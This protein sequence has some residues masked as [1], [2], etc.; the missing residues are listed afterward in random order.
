MISQLSFWLSRH[1]IGN[2][3]LR[4]GDIAVIAISS[5]LAIFWHFSHPII[6]TWDSHTYFENALGFLG[7]EGRGT[8]YFRLPALP[9]LIL[10]SLAP[11]TGVLWPFVVIQAVMGIII[12][13]LFYRTLAFFSVRLALAA[14]L[15][16]LCSFLPF[17]H[18]KAVMTEHVFLFFITVTLFATARLLFKGGVWSGVL[19]AL[20]LAGMALARA[21]GAYFSILVVP[22][23]FLGARNAR[24]HVLLGLSL[25]VAIVGG[26]IYWQSHLPVRNIW[27]TGMERGGIGLTHTTGKFL[28]YVLYT[29]D[30]RLKKH[31][32][33]FVLPENG[34]NTKKLFETVRNYFEKTPNAFDHNIDKSMFGKYRG[35]V[36]V[37]MA[38]LVKNPTNPGY[39]MMWSVVDAM[40]NPEQADRLFFDAWL[41]TVCTHPMDSL[42][43]YLE[44]LRQSLFEQRSLVVPLTSTTDSVTHSEYARRFQKEIFKSG[45][46]TTPTPFDVVLD[47]WYRVLQGAAV[48]LALVTAPWALVNGR[49]T[50]WLWLTTAALSAGIY[51]SVVIGTIAEFRYVYYALMTSLVAATLGIRSLIARYTKRA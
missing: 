14:T 28:F 26:V 7:T 2:P 47:K 35:K 29:T 4:H 19:L 8:W 40:L 49:R 50:R 31:E 17:L 45:S 36:D 38:D 32:H 51:A 42:L 5:I 34:P 46:L 16:L 9:A 15:L 3:T 12:A 11:L 13:W 21:N 44:N 37:L 48:V 6:W 1:G 24:C 27:T 41:E 20:G 25:Y 30:V 23:A 39:W 18:A 10:L 22:L 43:M 33:P